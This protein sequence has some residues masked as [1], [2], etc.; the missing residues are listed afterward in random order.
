MFAGAGR[1]VGAEETQKTQ[2]RFACLLGLSL[3]F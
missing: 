1:D 3:L 2:G